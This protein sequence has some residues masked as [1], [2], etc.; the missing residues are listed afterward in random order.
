MPPSAAS[1][2]SHPASPLLSLWRPLGYLPAKTVSL[3][4]TELP[5]CLSADPTA[6]RTPQTCY[7]VILLSQVTPRR[8]KG[9]SQSSVLEVSLSSGYMKDTEIKEGPMAS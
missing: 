3:C 5:L 1:F 8:L 9:L 6:P 2:P 4:V 7:N